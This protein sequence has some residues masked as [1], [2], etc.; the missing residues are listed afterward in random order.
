MVVRT[1]SYFLVEN[2]GGDRDLVVHKY[3]HE[4]YEI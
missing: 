3:L 1:E 4:R 2:V